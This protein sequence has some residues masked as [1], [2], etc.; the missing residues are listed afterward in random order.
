MEDRIILV[1]GDNSKWY[2]Q[3]IFIVRKNI[4]QSKV[5]VDFVAEAEKI[6]NNYMRIKTTGFKPNHLAH[7]SSEAAP[8]AHVSPSRK[9]AAKKKSGFDTF[10]NS[11][12]FI[13]CVALL[14][15]LVYAWM[16]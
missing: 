5:P 1:E 7:S 14:G 4:P 13:G 6:V 16:M 10:I 9:P 2:E 8:T 11:V 3:A 12:L 15:L